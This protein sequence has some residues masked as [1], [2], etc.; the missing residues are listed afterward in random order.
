WN[1]TMVA[2]L[3][4]EPPNDR[5]GVLQDIHWG[6]GLVGYFPTYTLGNLYAAQ[7]WAT[8]GRELPERDAAIARGELRPILGWLRERIHQ[9]GGT[10]V[11]ADLIERAT[12]EPP[13]PRY[14]IEYLAAKYG[15]VYGF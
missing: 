2:T 7:L 9:H 4:V 15:Q 12:G 1:E 3:G 5:E 8:I 14:L 6:F 11:P 10:Y 13:N